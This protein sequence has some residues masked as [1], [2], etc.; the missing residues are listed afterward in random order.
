MRRH[1]RLSAQ[2]DGV[3]ATS[4]LIYQLTGGLISMT[5]HLI[6]SAVLICL[7]YTAAA[8]QTPSA[9]PPG[10]RDPSGR[11]DMHNPVQ[12]QHQELLKELEIKRAEGTHKQ[13]V[14]RAKESAQLSTEL[15]DSYAQQKTLSQSDLKKLSRLEKLAR[16]LRSD[17]GG[18]ADEEPL[19]EPPK[20][21]SATLSRLATLT[22]D[23]R[24]G[25]EKTPRQVVSASLI[26]QTNELIELIKVARTFAH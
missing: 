7:G 1:K 24:K 9:L 21:L 13:N 17:S 10:G 26:A 15:R 3:R 8:A 23:L 16:Q 6:I 25:V 5:R 20:D 12:D 18:S 14:E 11:D 19:K 2:P 22:D 4:V